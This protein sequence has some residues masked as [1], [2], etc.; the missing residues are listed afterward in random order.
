MK[1]VKTLLLIGLFSW[2]GLGLV[3]SQKQEEQVILYDDFFTRNGWTTD[4]TLTYPWSEKGAVV[5]GFD[6]GETADLNGLKKQCLRISP[7]ALSKPGYKPGTMLAGLAVDY[8]FETPVERNH[9]TLKIEFDALWEGINNSGWGESGRIVLTLIHDYPED[10]IAFNTIFDVKKEAP[11]GRPA[12][13]LRIR[14]HDKTGP[15]YSGSFLLYG[16]GMD[17]EG[18]F[19]KYQNTY[20]LP[21]FSSEPGGTSPGLL[22]SF[23]ASPTMKNEQIPT[24]A[25]LFWKHYTWIVKP[26]RMEFYQRDC[27]KPESENEL[28]F[29]MQ[30]PVTPETE[31]EIIKE[32]NQAHQTNITKLPAMYNWFPEVDAL[33]VYFRG[34][35]QTNLANLVV[36]TIN[37]T[38]PTQIT[39]FEENHIKVWPNPSDGNF[40]IQT[41]LADQFQTITITNMSGHKIYQNDI[42]PDE[43][44][45]NI[46]LLGSQSGIY[47]VRL[48]GI[49]Q[50]KTVKIVIQ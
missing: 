33:R 19:E 8:R 9:T 27:R 31:T 7:E 29:F 42:E 22:P 50:T 45:I 35:Q 43:R 1:G 17:K 34:E 2:R 3:Y 28:V 39:E 6:L 21:G 46:Q 13:N 20:W 48:E 4:L 44:L 15:Y 30:I 26:E 38:L 5:S 16:G 47:L 49:T 36:K 18:E 32:I 12:Y 25:Y 14:N 24:V 10:S 37:S 41:E 11:F 23:P 40:K